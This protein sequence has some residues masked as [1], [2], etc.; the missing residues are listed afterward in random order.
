MQLDA[1][2]SME[3]ADLIGV[4][5][6]LG[7]DVNRGVR[8]QQLIF[9]ILSARGDDESLGGVGVMEILPDGF[10]F[11]RSAGSNY[12]PSPDDIYVSP[13]QIRRFNLQKGDTGVGQ[14]RPPKEGERYFALLKVES[15][16]AEDPEDGF[17]PSPGIVEVLAFG[18]G[19]G[20]RVDTHLRAGDRIPPNYDSMIA[21][22][23][24]HG[25]D[26]PQAI[27][28]MAAALDATRIEGVKT[29]IGLH[30]RI[31]GWDPFTSG[32]YD[33]TSLEAELMGAH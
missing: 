12:F 19:E 24:A 3:I 15:I 16:N 33:T 25:P 6:D 28:R 13:R 21:K 11:L 32:A 26:R 20:I 29:N 1:L 22:L 17:R 8:K 18:E 30:Q 9:D 5:T 14:I 4:A 10:G 27:A 31:L 7:I 2:K 23:I